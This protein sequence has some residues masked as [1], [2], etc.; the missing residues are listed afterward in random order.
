[1]KF[2]VDVVDT[3]NMT[4]TPVDRVFTLGPLKDSAYPAVGD[5]KIVLPGTQW[6]ALRIVRAD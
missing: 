5:G 4:I 1:M 3:W 2:H 6:M